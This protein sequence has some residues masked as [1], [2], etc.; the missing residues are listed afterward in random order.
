MA[1]LNMVYEKRTRRGRQ[2]VL[3]MFE[4]LFTVMGNWM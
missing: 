4:L 2:G 1:A 3:G